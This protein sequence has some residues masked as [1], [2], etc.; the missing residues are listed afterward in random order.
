MK[1]SAANGNEMERGHYLPKGGPTTLGL[2]AARDLSRQP[3]RL[4]SRPRHETEFHRNPC[5]LATPICDLQNGLR[6]K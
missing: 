1:G 5:D 6:T 3:A 4:E 2:Y